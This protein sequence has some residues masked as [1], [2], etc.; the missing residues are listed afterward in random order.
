MSFAALKARRAARDARWGARGPRAAVP[1][2]DAA[3]EDPGAQP[4]S[5]DAPAPPPRSVSEA[6]ADAALPYT[7]PELA[8]THLDVF[9]T[10]TEG[11][12]LRRAPH[13]PPAGRGEELLAVEPAV[14][15]LSAAQASARCHFCFRPSRTLQRCSRCKFAHYCSEACQRR[16]W[17]D[18]RHRDECAALQRFQASA[19][20]AGH[21]ATEPGAAVRAVAQLVWQRRKQGLDSAFW[22]GIASMQ[23]HR[24]DMPAEQLE[25]CAQLAF[26]V[27]QFVSPDA[28]PSSGFA[29]ARAL[30]DLVCA[31]QINA[32]TLADA[33]L[34]PIGVSVSVPIALCNHAC[35]PNAVV[36]FPVA[37]QRTMRLV[38]IRRIAPGD[39]VRTSYVDLA[40]TRAQR[41]ATLVRRYLFTCTCALCRRSAHPPPHDTDPRTA[42]WCHERDCAG[43]CALPDWR[44]LP[45]DDDAAAE[46]GA[47]NRCGRRSTLNDAH[48]IHA[49]WRAAHQLA[50]R[51]QAAMHSSMHGVPLD[52]LLP[53]LRW[54]GAL[55]PPCNALL[56]TLL[57]A[58]HVLAIEQTR[59][60]EATQLAF[61]LC[62]GMQAR[63]ASTDESMLYPPGHPLRAV[64]LATLGKLL[65]H[66]SVPCAPLLPR[67]SALPADRGVQLAL[68][69]QALVQALD[70]AKIGF[71]RAVDGGDVAAEARD[72]LQTL[73][74]EQ[75]VLARRL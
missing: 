2:G 55:V 42:C 25:A 11:R 46:T 63:G 32:F 7:P 74:E 18:A 6:P 36:V 20:D 17:S 70:E 41:Q 28:L 50:E 69:K 33:Q 3:A 22:R 30:L 34:D 52:E 23:T 37:G 61:V 58:A 75:A 57:H 14:S 51:V 26:Q 8:H 65:L 38:A 40:E 73:E 4:A 39:E 43:W 67:V 27:A 31:F 45:V 21:T 16:A 35:D 64:L 10:A 66:E 49:R 60:P 12:G 1:E 72:A 47:C 53:T 59:Y 62:A 29:N 54:L 24:A 13:A 56:W 15:V 5:A 71:G 19:R 44:T 48:A 68:A 9:S